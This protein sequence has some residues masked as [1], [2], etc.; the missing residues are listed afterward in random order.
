M[1]QVLVIRKDLILSPGKVVAQGAHASMGA[2]ND[3]MNRWDAIGMDMVR[4]WEEGGKKKVV[5]AILSEEAL[6]DLAK[7]CDKAN[8]GHYLVRDAGKT[9]V[10]PNTP[11]ALGIG[12]DFSRHIDKLTGN[13]RLF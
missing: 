9:E 6:L 1:K 11:T 8:I 4:A 12:P 5:C 10:G 7:E 2:Y 3:A 13:L